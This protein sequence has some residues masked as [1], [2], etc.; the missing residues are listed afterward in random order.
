MINPGPRALPLLPLLSGSVSIPAKNRNLPGR[1]TTEVEH[2][3]TST[4]SH[5]GLSKEPKT[6]AVRSASG[7][8]SRRARQHS[9]RAR[10]DRR[11]KPK[12]SQGD[13]ETMNESCRR[14]WPSKA[15][16]FWFDVPNVATYSMSDAIRRDQLL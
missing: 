15:H 8:P 1:L 7:R 11:E 14:A 12:R 2:G 16:A 10:A 9:E 3:R 13:R 6:L 4:G 5:G